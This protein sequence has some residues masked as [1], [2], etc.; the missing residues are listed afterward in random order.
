MTFI[1]P[2]TKISLKQINWKCSLDYNKFVIKY[3]YY[4]YVGMRN[5]F[6][7][8]KFLTP[9]ERNTFFYS[10]NNVEVFK[11]ICLHFVS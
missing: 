11:K 9:I 3:R 8:F 7:Y 5:R 2:F 10:S 1:Y 4:R 6:F